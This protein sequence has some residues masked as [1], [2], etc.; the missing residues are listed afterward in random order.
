MQ[1]HAIIDIYLIPWG[2][3]LAISL[4]ILLIGYWLTGHIVRLVKKRLNKTKLDAMLV[5]FLG[6]ILKAVLLLM[7]VI[8]ALSQLGVDTTSLIALSGAAG[9]GIG[10][11]VKDS[12]QNF[13]SGVMLILLQPFKK[14]DLVEIAGISG[15]VDQVNLFSTQMHTDDNREIIVPNSKIYGDTIT[16]YS[17][18]DTRRV[19]MTFRIGYGDDLKKAKQIL[20]HLVQSDERILETPAP[21]V[22]LAELGDSSVNFTVRA[23]VKSADYRNVLWDMNE[24]VKLM[25]DNA[26]I[27]IPYPQMDVDVHRHKQTANSST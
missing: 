15:V 9:L 10:L 23:W 21:V 12:L 8:A 24:K 6:K 11:A 18:R 7:V 16:N 26:G 27:S 25:F 3:K 20:E 5:D 4:A 14:G 1:G 2:I 22:A 13:A 17:A 19:D